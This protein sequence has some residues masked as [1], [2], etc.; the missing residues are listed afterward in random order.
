MIKISKIKKD[1]NNYLN[2]DNLSAATSIPNG[3]LK[4][5]IES[6]KI[7][8][9]IIQTKSSVVRIKF[10]DNEYLRYNDDIMD[11]LSKQEQIELD[12]YLRSLVPG[13]DMTIYKFLIIG[14]NGD[15]PLYTLDS[16]SLIPD[17]SNI[18]EPKI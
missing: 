10:S 11:T 7:P 16:N 9:M 17:Y 2:N 8:H 6:G 4:I 14:W 12:K 15:N 1:I 13:G 3:F 18:Q 5:Y